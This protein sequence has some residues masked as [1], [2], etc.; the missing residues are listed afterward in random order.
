LDLGGSPAEAGTTLVAQ[1]N[2]EKA[3]FDNGPQFL[4]ARTI[5][6]TPTWH[7]DTMAAAKAA[8]GGDR[9]EFVDVY[10]FFLLLKTQLSQAK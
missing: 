2:G 3:A 7:A 4:M 1:I 6:K 10:S 5:L 8:P 9:I